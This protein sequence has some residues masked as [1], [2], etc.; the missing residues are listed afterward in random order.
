MTHLFELK[1]RYGDCYRIHPGGLIQRM[2]MP[3]FSPSDTWIMRG[4]VPVNMNRITVSVEQITPQWLAEH[5]LT[6][7]NG[8][9]RYTVADLD[10]GT[11]RVWGNTKW[12]GVAAIWFPD[13]K[14]NL[15][16]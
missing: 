5:P 13:A 6:Y 11:R 3:D 1:T 4:L 7:K 14:H 2:D 8:N 15:R 16:G 10:H 9:P 12:H